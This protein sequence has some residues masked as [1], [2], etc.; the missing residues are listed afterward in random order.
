[1]AFI[2]D[3]PPPPPLPCW[4]SAPPPLSHV[5]NYYDYS[6]ELSIWTAV[7]GV[8]LDFVFKYVLREQYIHTHC[9]LHVYLLKVTKRQMC[10][11]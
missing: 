10:I 8:S 1:M 7:S 2:V 11:N 6:G 4:A 9:T 5:Y 3:T